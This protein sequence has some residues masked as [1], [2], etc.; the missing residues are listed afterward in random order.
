[1]MQVTYMAFDRQFTETFDKN[2]T[3]CQL[4]TY[5]HSKCHTFQIINIEYI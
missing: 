4:Y 2:T 5:L 3:L 1:M